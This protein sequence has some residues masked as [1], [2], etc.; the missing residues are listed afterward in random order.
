[1]PILTYLCLAIYVYFCYFLLAC[2]HI[3]IQKQ[4]SLYCGMFQNVIL[5]QFRA[6]VIAL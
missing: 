5:K 3:H 4:F 2:V 1:M 6:Y